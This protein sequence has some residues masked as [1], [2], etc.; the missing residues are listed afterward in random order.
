MGLE[1]QDRFDCMPYMVTAQE[2]VEC[3]RYIPASR[4]WLGGNLMPEY[5]GK[6]LK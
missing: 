2:F 3:Y 5:V 4:G 1:V 6:M